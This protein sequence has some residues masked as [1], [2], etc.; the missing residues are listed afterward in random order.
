MVTRKEK[1][2]LL[3]VF[4]RMDKYGVYCLLAISLTTYESNQRLYFTNDW[5]ETVSKLISREKSLRESYL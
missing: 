5:K 2:G 1:E 4:C 3:V